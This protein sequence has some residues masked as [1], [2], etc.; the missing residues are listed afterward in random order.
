VNDERC[1]NGDDI[2]TAS[3]VLARAAWASV[4]VLGLAIVPTAMIAVDREEQA[5]PP[6]QDY[7]SGAYLYRTF[8]ASCHGERGKGDGPVAPLLVTRPPDL[9]TIAARAAGRFNQP[10]VFAA[11]DGRRRVRGHGPAEMPVWG[12]VLKATEGHDDA[13]IKKRIDALVVHVESLQGR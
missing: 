1:E 6:Q 7:N 2:M 11:I 8:C 3:L 9:T 5:K 12:D 4:F 13:I 10:E